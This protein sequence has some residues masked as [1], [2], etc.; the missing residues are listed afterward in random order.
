MEIALIHPHQLFA[1]HPA[2][3]KGRHCYLFEDPL[4]FGNDARWPLAVHQQKL[5]LHR[6]SMQAYAAELMGMGHI[7]DPEDDVMMM[8]LRRFAKN[9]GAELRV[10][11]SP[12]FL[13][14]TDFLATHIASKRK[15]FMASFYQSQR[16]RM[17]ILIEDDESPIGGKWS[18]DTDNRAKLPNK[19][20]VPSEPRTAPNQWVADAIAHVKKHFS[21]NP[22]DT[23]NFRW[24]VTR[25]DSMTWLDEFFAQ[26]FANF[27]AYEDAISTR[28]AYIHHAAI[29]PMLNIGL[30]DPADIVTRA[31]AN[32]DRKVPL[33]SLE[34]FIRQVIGWSVFMMCIFLNYCLILLYIILCCF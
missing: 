15:P 11:D 23:E 1:N 13:T 19:Y 34:G 12:N 32:A 16:K 29:T 4:I 9:R 28:H 18:F 2:I 14:P 3:A 33:N 27:G 5:V 20:Q 26:R 25:A 6:A 17:R 10:H 22:G 8:R 24:P 21:K 7:A 31:L 30:L